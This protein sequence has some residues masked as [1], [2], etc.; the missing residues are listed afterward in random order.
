M[1]RWALRILAYF[2]FSDGMDAILEGMEDP[3]PHVRD[4]AIY[5]LPFMEGPRA[6]EAL[7]SATRSPAAATRAS[8]V[9]ALGNCTGDARIDGAAIGALDDP[10]PWV[11]YYACQTAGRL[12]IEAAV[13]RLSRLLDDPAGHVRVAAIEGLSHF[14]DVTAHDALV[15]AAHSAEDDVRR[16]AI[17]GLGIACPPRALDTVAEALRSP[18]GASR[19]VAVWALAGFDSPL[20]NDLLVAAAAG[21]EESVRNG[22]IG[23]LA[24]R[25]GKEATFALIDILRRSG[26]PALVHQALAHPSADRI[27]GILDSLAGAD[28]ELAAQLTSAL[29]RMSDPPSSAALVRA[30]GL[31][32]PAARKAAATT[33]GGLG[34]RE[35]SSALKIAATDD[36]HPEVRRICA[37]VLG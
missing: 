35:A 11:R 10:D 19:L 26:D 36:P 8:A 12:Q 25:Q 13:P 16:A 22:A 2:G 20:V 31:P 17:I 4:S 9:R 15:V 37:A 33:L 3:D 27:A 29:A 34:T 23:A 21:E 18:D 14:D 7:L 24:G 6:R 28:D 5:A 32:N 1:R 30:L